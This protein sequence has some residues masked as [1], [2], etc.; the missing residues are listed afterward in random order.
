MD[1]NNM[2]AILMKKHGSDERKTG[3]EKSAEKAKTSY[4][5]GLKNGLVLLNFSAPVCIYTSYIVLIF[6]L[7][8]IRIAVI[9]KP[10]A[11]M[12]R[13]TVLLKA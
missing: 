8:S 6:L 7:V 11:Q 13:S 4:A 2:K 9:V 12:T 3:L 5:T 10:T 1:F